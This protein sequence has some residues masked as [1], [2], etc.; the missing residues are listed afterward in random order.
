MKIDTSE[1]AL[2]GEHSVQVEQALVE[3]KQIEVDGRWIGFGDLFA[4]QKQALALRPAD[5]GA[6]ARP[7][8][9]AQPRAIQMLLEILDGIV[10]GQDSTLGVEAFRPAARSVN[11]HFGAAD[12]NAFTVEFL[13]KEKTTQTEQ[14][15]FAAQG[16]VTTQDGRQIDFDFHSN[17]SRETAKETDTGGVYRL[18]KL[19]D[20]LAVNLDG[21][22]IRL[23][24]G[25]TAFDLQGDGCVAQ[26]PKLASGS[27][28]LVLDANG[29]GKADSGLELFGT[30]SGNGFADLA[31]WDKDRN[32]WIDE[33]DGVYGKLRIWQMDGQGGPALKTLKECGIGAIY[34][35]KAA[36][37][38]S[39][40]DPAGQLLGQVRASG[41]FLKEDGTAGLVQQ[42]DL[43]V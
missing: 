15:D 38:F 39:H 37:E 13:R 10:P 17:L 21:K 14:A 34:L 27:G 24:D 26:I 36:T 25:R 4:E 7:V 42:I 9:S 30:R 41:V 29:N 31:A 2:A 11:T 5:T 3:Q 6:A 28:F 35:G 22:G 1:V 33:N 18:E 8:D 23:T 19:K 40:I 43:A 12:T 20:P 16:R 32:G